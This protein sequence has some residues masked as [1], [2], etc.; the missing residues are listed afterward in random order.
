MKANQ[1][2][3]CTKVSNEMIEDILL[4]LQKSQQSS[5]VRKAYK[6][7]AIFQAIKVNLAS[8]TESIR[9]V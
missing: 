3:H 1:N 5:N 8:G 6:S 7:E 9:R 4:R 2:I